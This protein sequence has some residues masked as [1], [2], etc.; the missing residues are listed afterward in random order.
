MCFYLKPPRGGLQLHVLEET[1]NQRTNLLNDLI[2]KKNLPTNFNCLIDG[3]AL[4]RTGHFILRILS[5]KE[6]STLDFLRGEKI[7][8]SLRLDSYD[9]HML[10]V[11]FNTWIKHIKDNLEHNQ[12]PP[13]KLKFLNLFYKLCLQFLRKDIFEHIF[14]NI[15]STDCNLIYFES[16]SISKNF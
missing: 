1:I 5:V 15:H 9:S 4:D 16:N 14:C 2:K 6:G 13:K 11:M 8:F 7:L 3:T 10:K 12:I